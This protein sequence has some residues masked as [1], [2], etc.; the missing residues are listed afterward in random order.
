[1]RRGLEIVAAAILVGQLCA[2]VHAQ[3]R[4]SSGSDAGSVTKAE[5]ADAVGALIA[6]G[7]GGVAR[8]FR[9]VLFGYCAASWEGEWMRLCDRH[10]AF[11]S[12]LQRERR[13]TFDDIEFRYANEMPDGVRARCRSSAPGSTG[14]I[15]PDCLREEMDRERAREIRDMRSGFQE[16]WRA[17]LSRFER[18]CNGLLRR[19][20]DDVPEALPWSCQ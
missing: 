16:E 17:A 3:N 1:M 8:T 6:G 14:G 20:P 4:R 9:E 13:L 2:P 15:D 19:Q 7:V 12:E 11:L 5:I 18:E 10:N